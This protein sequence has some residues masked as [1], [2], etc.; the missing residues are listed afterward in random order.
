MLSRFDPPD[1]DDR[2]LTEPGTDPWHD[3][4]PE[5]PEPDPRLSL[6]DHLCVLARALTLGQ[7]A[8]YLNQGAK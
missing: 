5:E 3:D 1:F 8:Q 7:Y 4:E 6:T 2:A